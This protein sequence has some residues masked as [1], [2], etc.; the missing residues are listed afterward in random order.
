MNS[1]ESRVGLVVAEMQVLHL[2]HTHLLRTARTLCS[3]V[4]VGLGSA[5]LHGVPG[6]PFTFEQRK[7]MIERV[8]GPKTFKFLALQDIDASLDTND[9]VDYVLNR[10][11][12]HW[13]KTPTD[14]FC[15]SEMDARPYCGR[16]APNAVLE[17]KGDGGTIYAAGDGSRRLHIVARSPRADF[18][19]RD[20]R[21][22]I[23]NRD[24]I[25][26][27]SVPKKLWE[28]IEENYPPHLRVAIRAETLPRNVPVGT[29]CVLESAPDVVQVLRADGKWR[30]FVPRED[31]KATH[32]RP[33]PPRSASPAPRCKAV[34]TP[35]GWE[36]QRPGK[37]GCVEVLWVT[38]DEGAALGVAAF[39]NQNCGSAALAAALPGLVRHTRPVR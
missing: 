13:M 1:S 30:P 2:G 6:H 25:W 11:S 26:R 32:R 29:R 7:E 4:I 14:Y 5:Q 23:E 18:R 12:R 8:F 15:G 35:R 38:D 9:W 16:F 24:P 39:L 3:E 28:W 27:R 22:L 31:E 34:L 36:V 10:I 21:W 19:G 17:L 37:G 33:E 20:V